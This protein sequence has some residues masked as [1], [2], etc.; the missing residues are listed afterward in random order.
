VLVKKDITEQFPGLK[1]ENLKNSDFAGKTIQ[2]IFSKPLIEESQIRK[3]DFT[4]S[5][6]AFNQGNGS[7]R[8]QRLPLMC[9]LSSLNAI[10]VLDV[11]NDGRPD[12]VTGGNEFDFPPQFGRLDGSS[13]EVLINTGNGNFETVKPSLSGLNVK[14]EMKGILVIRRG[15]RRFLLFAVNNQPPVLYQLEN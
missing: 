8:I 4:S 10:A 2:E 12:L 6:I 15:D 7:F 9:Q 3:F 11:N 1:K 14:G 13:G 5:V